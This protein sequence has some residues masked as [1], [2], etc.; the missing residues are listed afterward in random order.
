MMT[1]EQGAGFLTKS[2]GAR[3]VPFSASLFAQWQNLSQAKYL[4]LG[5]KGAAQN[6]PED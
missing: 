5:L 3:D 2:M 6:Q 4:G 1:W